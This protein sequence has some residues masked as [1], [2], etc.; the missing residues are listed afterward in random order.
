[1]TGRPPLDVFAA[2]RICSPRA[3]RRE[4]RLGRR[5]GVGSSATSSGT[6]AR[7]SAERSSPLLAAARGPDGRAAAAPSG[8]SPSVSTLVPSWAARMVSAS[9]SSPDDTCR[10]P[11]TGSWKRSASPPRRDDASRRTS[12]PGTLATDPSRLRLRSC[13]R[14]PSAPA[15]GRARAWRTMASSS[16]EEMLCGV[17]PCRWEHKRRV[18]AVKFGGGNLL[19]FRV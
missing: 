6:A 17:E 4:R 16:W 1:M 2:C 11:R 18:H 14:K 19:R 5:L 12:S 9:V 3:H 13:S 10:A 15:S 8:S 7:W